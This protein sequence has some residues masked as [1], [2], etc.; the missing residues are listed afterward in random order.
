MDRID[1]VKAQLAEGMAVLSVGSGTVTDIAKH[2]CYLYERDQGYHV[3]FVVYQTANSVSAYTSNM[4]PVFIQGVKRT[5][6][7]R[8]PEALVCDLETLRDAPREMTAAGVGDLLAAF[9]SFPDWYLAHQ[10][11]LDDS[12]SVLPQTLMGPLYEIILNQ[13]EEI[14]SNQLSGM[15]MLAK[16]ISL[17][18]LAMSLSHTT[19]PLSGYEHVMSH[20]LDMLNEHRSQPLAQHGSQV[21]L[22]AVVCCETYQ[23][24]MEQFDPS[25]VILA[26]V[27]PDGEM[28]RTRI[29]Q[30]FAKVDPSGKAGEECWSDYGQKLDKWNGSKDI[31]VDFL[32]N[33]E[34][35]R[36][37]LQDSTRLPS[38]VIDI[39]QKIEAPIHFAELQPGFDAP[40]VK[41]AF[42]N[43]PLMR[44]RL[45]LGDLL[46]FFNWDREMLW[47]RIEKNGLV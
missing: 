12:Y 38:Q 44:K 13:A 8:Y 4:A 36:A 35:H 20:I 16:L 25:E 28:M 9:V 41:F 47:D 3:P 18:G 5:L 15:A 33:W 22:A 34:Q 37:V 2:A 10:L 30:A 6:A 23:A 21:A 42:L 29:M 43:A 27:F 46:I 14:R 31:L 1:K 19:A 11:G 40:D 32:Q 45:T 7:S 39:L 24:F 17:A 26:S